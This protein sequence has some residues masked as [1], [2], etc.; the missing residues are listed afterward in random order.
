[1]TKFIR[2]NALA[3]VAI[4]ILVIAAAWEQQEQR[5]NQQHLRFERHDDGAATADDALGLRLDVP[6]PVRRGG[7]P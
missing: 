5:W 7:V 1:M 3:P 4:L 6:G 2:R